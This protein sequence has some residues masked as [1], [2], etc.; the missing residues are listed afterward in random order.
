MSACLNPDYP[1]LAHT[2][3]LADMICAEPQCGFLMAGA[4]IHRW[5]VTSLLHRGAFAD[6]YLASR[7]DAPS[8]DQSNVLIKVLRALTTEPVAL[9][10]QKMELLLSLRH[11]HIHPV[12]AAG[13]IS[14]GG[15]IYLLTR[16]ETQGALS[17]ISATATSLPTLAVGG[18]VR[19][20]ADALD[21]A[22]ERLLVHGRLKLENCLAVGPAT[23]QVSDFYQ[24]LLDQESQRVNVPLAAPE[25]Q[26]SQTE[27][28][29][30]QYSLALLT[31]QLLISNQPQIGARSPALLPAPGSRLPLSVSEIRPDLPRQVD[32]ALSQ[33]LSPQPYGRYKNVTSFALALQAALEGQ[34]SS[35]SW[36]MISAS[37]PP[38]V[39][40]PPSS[41]ASPWSNPGTPPLLGGQRPPAA[42]VTPAR[43]GPL[44]PLCILPGHTS[45]PTMLRWAPDGSHL[46]SIGKEQ[47]IY[48][49]RVERRIGTP[50]ATLAGHSSEVLAL[51]WSPNSPTL[52]S[53]A[54]DATVRIWMTPNT[55]AQA[56]WWGHDGSVTSL[57]YAPNGAHI[58]SGGSDRTIRVWD[59]QGNALNVWQA[60]GRAVTALA[61]SPD[62]RILAS[63]GADFL[64]HLWDSKTGARVATLDGHKDEIHHLA[65]SPSG[66]LLA[67]YA[68]KKDLRICLWDRQSYRLTAVL[69]GHTRE[70]VGLHWPTEGTWLA[71]ASGDATLRYWDLHDGLGQPIGLPISLQSPPLCMAGAPTTDLIALGLNDQLIQVLQIQRTT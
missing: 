66:E 33:A 23:V 3:T 64:I 6:L 10:Q 70:I 42:P 28:A 38:P 35:T 25:Q 21:Y 16:F 30:D 41:L 51:S 57:G 18:I 43:P 67:S 27:A 17:R 62:G 32:Q 58:A 53:G 22:H 46:A 1:H 65:W 34:G 44:L 54:V 59:M 8:S 26:Y 14:P 63:G 24:S 11:P 19:Q 5:Q 39:S 12:I 37:S 52:A 36:P 69:S 68:G 55:T 71:T 4:I 50:L 45:P 7:V 60:H 61:W 56:A 20:I 47:T 9:R 40:S 29:S 48:L 49:W 15:W 31:Y 2:T 13:W